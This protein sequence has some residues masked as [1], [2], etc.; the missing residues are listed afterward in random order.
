VVSAARDGE[1][2]LHAGEFASEEEGVQRLLA[3][4]TDCLRGDALAVK[5]KELPGDLA[6]PVSVGSRSPHGCRW[7]ILGCALD[8]P[9]PHPRHRQGPRLR[10]QNHSPRTSAHDPLRDRFGPQ[11]SSRGK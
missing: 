4:R 8:P 7:A 5:A 2:F 11:A 9:R 6:T 10:G 3:G 1:N